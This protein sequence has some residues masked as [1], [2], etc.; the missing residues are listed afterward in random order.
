[1]DIY[2]YL[3]NRTYRAVRKLIAAERLEM[4]QKAVDYANYEMVPGDILE[5]GVFTGRSL[6]A[7]EYALASSQYDTGFQRRV[8]GFDSFEGLPPSADSH[9]R[10]DKDNCSVNHLNPAAGLEPGVRVTEQTVRKL[11]GTL[12]LR[13]PDL[14]TGDFAETIP[15][16]IPAQ[17][18]AAAV[19]HIDCD[20]YESA[21]TVLEHIA[22][23][24]QEGTVILFDDWFHYKANPGK[25]EQRAFREF[26]ETHPE[27]SAAQYKTYGV[28]CN[29]FILA[30][31]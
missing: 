23:A 13:Q 9:P 14:I 2:R 19:V 22:P 16:M 10:W 5:F 28:F 31:R 30:A 11:F 15:G 1:M 20:L 25:G 12:R 3:T 8:M 6:A 21:R 7:L 17:C 27:W 29:A 18:S 26:L 24:L 4:F